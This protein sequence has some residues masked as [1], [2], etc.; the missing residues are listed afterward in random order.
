MNFLQKIIKGIVGEDGL[1]ELKSSKF[2][3]IVNGN[4][5][6]KSYIRKQ[7]PLVILLAV[8]AI[9]YVDNGFYC[10]KQLSRVIKL[11]R[12]LQD[13]KY[14]SLTISAELMETSR[15]SN[16]RKLIKERGLTLIEPNTPPVV[17]NVNKKTEEENDD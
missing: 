1:N 5:L 12:D 14:E 15:Q 3:D 6:T 16:V 8:I 10:E 9:F 4:I 2:R 11:K 17:I 13:I 7:Y